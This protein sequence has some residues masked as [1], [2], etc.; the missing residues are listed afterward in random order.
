M[1]LLTLTT[2]ASHRL[3]GDVIS[4][5]ENGFTWGNLETGN[6]MFR[7]IQ[8]PDSELW[9]SP[10]LARTNFAL[11]ITG[12]ISETDEDTWENYASK[13]AITGNDLIE[14]TT[15]SADPFEYSS[16]FVTGLT[17]KEL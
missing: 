17:I 2:G 6:S 3:L 16:S 1:E 10:E 9:G 15:T 12:Y 13:Y 4:V 5:H 11:Q 14:R 7:I 8:C